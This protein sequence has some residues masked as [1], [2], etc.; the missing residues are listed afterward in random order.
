MA[1]LRALLVPALVAVLT[2]GCGPAGDAGPGDAGPG[3]AS[4]LAVAPGA[5]LPAGGPYA[6][7]ADAVRL[8]GGHAASAPTEGG[9]GPEVTWEA[10]HSRTATDALV[11]TYAARHGAP[12]DEIT[13]ALWRTPADVPSDVMEVCDASA[14]TGPWSVPDCPPVP[15]GAASVVMVSHIQR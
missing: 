2:G 7:P 14:P 8:C 15:D 11:R 5:A 10:F 9:P 4:P 3:A 13:C 6:P 1:P 12:S